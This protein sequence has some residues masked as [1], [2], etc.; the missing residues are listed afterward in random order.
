MVKFEV[1]VNE[2]LLISHIYMDSLEVYT[3][4]GAS[5]M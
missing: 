4:V 2:Y 5:T 3:L 1:K